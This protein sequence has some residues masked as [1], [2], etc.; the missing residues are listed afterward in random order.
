[1]EAY[2]ASYALQEMLTVKSDDVVG[3]LKTY[4]AIVKGESV[5]E[6]GIPESFRVLI[7][8]L[9]SLGLDMRLYNH[10]EQ[11]EIKEIA[12]ITE[13]P[14]TLHKVE[15]DE[16]IA[17]VDEEDFVLD[18]EDGLS[19]TDDD[20]IDEEIAEDQQNEGTLQDEDEDLYLDDL[21]DM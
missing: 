5:P 19:I 6:P 8:E 12:D 1:M 17:D 9:Q 11:I 18:S 13:D 3:R 14:K 15:P 2:G 10:N 16:L 4:E 20:F 7:K 21:D